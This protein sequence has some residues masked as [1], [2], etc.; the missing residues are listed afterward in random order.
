MIQVAI[1]WVLIQVLGREGLYLLY[2]RNE[3][4]E[5]FLLQLDAELGMV[6][7]DARVD[8]AHLV[9]GTL[10]LQL[11]YVAAED[12]V[13]GLHVSR[14]DAL[15]LLLEIVSDYPDCLLYDFLVL[16]TG[17]PV[18]FVQDLADV[19]LLFEL[20]GLAYHLVLLLQDL[21]GPLTEPFL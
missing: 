3:L 20:V 10:A 2:E 15:Y 7:L 1:G 6:L 12:L 14:V 21:L 16:H 5:D 11:R 18:Q 17:G 19:F 8:C 4:V 9:P 13:E